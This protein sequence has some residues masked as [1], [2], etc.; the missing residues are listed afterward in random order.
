MKHLYEIAK[1]KSEDPTFACLTLEQICQMFVGI[2]HT[3]GVQI[4]RDLDPVEYEEFLQE[5][6]VVVD[7]QQKQLQEAKEARLLRTA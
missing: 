4:V 6:K 7:E 2:S 5:R 3:C 1:L